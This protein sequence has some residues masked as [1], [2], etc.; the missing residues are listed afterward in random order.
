MTRDEIVVLAI[1]SG[2]ETE[3]FNSIDG[4]EVVVGYIIITDLLVE[5]ANLV[6]EKEREACAKMVENL[7]I[8]HPGSADRTLDQC[9]EAIR[10]RGQAKPHSGKTTY[11]WSQEKISEMMANDDGRD[12]G[13]DD[14]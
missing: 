1:D 3:L 13:P 5:F 10:A 12:L 11:N 2:F 7:V 4:D 8:F 9:A 6:V 14:Q